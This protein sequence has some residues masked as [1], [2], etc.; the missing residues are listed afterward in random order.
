MVKRR[1]TKPSTISKTKD[2]SKE[3]VVNASN[4][5]ET[6]SK[7]ASSC[8]DDSSTVAKKAKFDSNRSPRKYQ[9]YVPPFTASPRVSSRLRN[10]RNGEILSSQEGRLF[11][12]VEDEGN[13]VSNIGHKIGNTPGKSEQEHC[14]MGLAAKEEKTVWKIYL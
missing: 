1:R 10:K 7:H 11:N 4:S 14:A 13:M 12:D 6:C 3:K 2:N 8:A 9:K 5:D